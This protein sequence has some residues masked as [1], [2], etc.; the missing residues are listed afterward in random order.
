MPPP[1]TLVNTRVKRFSP[2][3]TSDS[4]DATDEFPGACSELINLIPDLTTKNVWTCRPGAT[5]ALDLTTWVNPDGGGTGG[6][7]VVVSTVV[8]EVVFGLATGVSGHDQPFAYNLGS[9]SFITVTLS[10]TPVFPAS[11]GIL[12]NFVGLLPTIAVIGVQ[13]IVT[14]PNF[15]LTSGGCKGGFNISSPGAPTYGTSDN[16]GAL[17]FVS[18]G[19]IPSWV[20]QFNQRAYYGVNASQPSMVAS[21]VLNAGVSTNAGQALTF[22]DDIQLTA[23]FPLGL[24]NQLGGIIQSLMI[25]KGVT[26]IYQVTGD[27]ALTTWAV[28]TLNVRTGTFFPRSICATPLGIAFI[29]PD[30][31]RIIDQNGVVNDPIG[32]A[33]KGVNAPFLP[34]LT[35][36]GTTNHMFIAAGC[37][38]T[39]IRVCVFNDD[40]AGLKSS[41]YWYNIPRKAW[42][43]PH[44][45][46]NSVEY[47]LYNGLFLLSYAYNT[48]LPHVAMLYSETNPSYATVYN[49][50]GAPMNWAMVSVPLEDNGA[51]AQSELS[52]M[53]LVAAGSNLTV[54]TELIDPSSG[55]VFNSASVAINTPGLYP[56]RVDFP[57]QSVFNRAQVSYSGA[58]AAGIKLG[59]TWMRVK[60]LSYITTNNG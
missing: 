21:D 5:T 10:G 55:S 48:N 17:T 30:G 36:V 45:P 28:N 44:S 35:I 4:L 20:C 6:T 49:E 24:S 32:V 1:T 8:G 52:E 43:G 13:V 39:N 11:L 40:N 46:S 38:T 27:Y 19:A 47:N 26:N 54:T 14:H 3:G 18:L 12:P 42:S 37:D 22:G 29:A 31:L 16:T 51:M 15:P 41:E 33:G 34:P 2:A 50:L 25:F 23:A 59:D 9:Q 7:Q 57:A 56:Y 53:Q 60:T 58:S